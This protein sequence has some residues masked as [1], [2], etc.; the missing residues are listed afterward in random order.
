[1]SFT[2][3]VSG[4]PSTYQ[5]LVEDG[6]KA[7]ERAAGSE[8]AFDAIISAVAEQLNAASRGQP[9]QAVSRLGASVGSIESEVFVDI[10]KWL[11][12]DP[13]DVPVPEDLTVEATFSTEV[14]DKLSG[15]VLVKDINKQRELTAFFEVDL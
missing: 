12:A 9:P 14:E 4:L 5:E 15:N 7:F 11:L 10:Q 1:M 6:K 2:L 8:M 13:S 3:R